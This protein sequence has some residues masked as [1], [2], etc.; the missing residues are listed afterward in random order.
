VY[1]DYQ[2]VFELI[3]LF[4]CPHKTK[5]ELPLL[6]DIQANIEATYQDGKPL[7]HL[8]SARDSDYDPNDPNV[9][10]IFVVDYVNFKDMAPNEIQEIFRDRHILVVGA[11]K[12]EDAKF[13][14]DSLS[15]VGDMDSPR[16]VMGMFYS[17][18]SMTVD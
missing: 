7:H 4:G 14:A 6:R 10:S 18:E 16:E 13:D 8:P 15:L 1:F 9:S 5:E 2:K 17:H 11:P 12:D 3:S